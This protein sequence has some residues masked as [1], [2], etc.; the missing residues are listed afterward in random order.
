LIGQILAASPKEDIESR[1]GGLKS[2]LMTPPDAIP[3]AA[4]EW[5]PTLMS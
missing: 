5:L 2:G 1:E 4:R 3:S